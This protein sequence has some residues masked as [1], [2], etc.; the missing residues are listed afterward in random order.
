M[1]GLRDRRAGR[2]RLPRDGR[3]VL[4][5]ELG[6][7]TRIEAETT[8]LFAETAPAVSRIVYEF[9]ARGD[10]PPIRF[11]WRDGSLA[12]PRSP[13]LANGEQL[14][15]GSSGQL[16]VG[17]DG[18]I[19]ADMYGREPR[20]F[21]TAL[22]EDL[23][24]S[25]PPPKYP[26]SPG[27]Y[28]E[29]IDAGKGHGAAGSGFAEHAGPLTE[30]VLLGNLAV[31]SGAA[32]EWDAERMRVSNVIE[33]NA[34]SRRGVPRGLESLIPDVVGTCRPLPGG[35][36]PC[37]PGQRDYRRGGSANHQAPAVVRA[38]APGRVVIECRQMISPVSPETRAVHGLAA[39]AFVT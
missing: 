27:V 6:Q 39:G 36:L 28:R 30:V 14:P 23:M 31:R 15:G 9:P 16:F 13:R 34:F 24:A 38:A 1:V 7:P 4:A 20:V 21:P 3:R 33:A 10:R 12:A 37:A 17:D 25:P 29:W 11:V 18:V 2:H 32:I 26:R 35:A 19:G 8:P 5:L 22:H